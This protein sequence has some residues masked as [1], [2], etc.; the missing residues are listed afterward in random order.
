MEKIDV[1]LFMI[2]PP[3]ERG[4]LPSI[5]YFALSA[6]ESLDIDPYNQPA[7]TLAHAGCRVFSFTLP[8]HHGTYARS[9]EA[10]ETYLQLLARGQDPIT[11]FLDRVEQKIRELETSGIISFQTTGLMG[12][13]RGC[14]IA[15]LLSL[16]I[17]ELRILQFFAPLI[18]LDKFELPHELSDR[19]LRIAIGN[20]DLR[21][22]TQ[23]ILR[24]TLDLL[25]RGSPLELDLFPSIGW[26]GH[27]TPPEVFQRGA[28]WLLGKVNDS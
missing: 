23:K 8:L 17:P 12:L 6:H 10:F 3:L 22:D 7:L 4:A 20:K 9:K 18:A 1:D 14:L 11:P 19:T 26:Q 15:G 24:W 16:R 25:E 5:F 27:G 28:L 2:G 21:V 13:S